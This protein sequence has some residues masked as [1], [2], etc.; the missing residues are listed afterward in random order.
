MTDSPHDHAHPHAHAHPE[1]PGAKVEFIGTRP[2]LSVA[3]LPASLTY[4]TEK[5]GFTCAW[6]WVPGQGFGGAAAPELAQLTR[7]HCVL[8]LAQRQQGAPGMWVHLDLESPAELAALH[9]EYTR[10]GATVV[11][12]P[13]DRPWGMREMR[14]QD[15]DG[16]TFRIA[17]PL[18]YEQA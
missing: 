16:H 18:R 13:A 4:Y 15:P 6:T 2:I 7:G 8:M 1:A 10:S 9:D 14:V 5:L 11:E 17:A 12:P 3:D